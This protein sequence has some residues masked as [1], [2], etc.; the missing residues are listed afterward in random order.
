MCK[1]C[2]CPKKT[3]V[4]LE[5]LWIVVSILINTY[6]PCRDVA[7]VFNTKSPYVLVL[8]LSLQKLSRKT[9]RNLQ[10][11]AANHA[12]RV[13]TGRAGH[14]CSVHP[15]PYTAL[16]FGLHTDRQRSL[17]ELGRRRI[18]KEIIIVRPLLT[19]RKR[20]TRERAREVTRLHTPVGR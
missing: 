19:S 7:A 12:Q 16:C 1:I 10:A 11:R 15:T 4:F 5:I 20:G 9:D 17:A 3:D 13:E 18:S 14:G 8:L 6:V 2:R